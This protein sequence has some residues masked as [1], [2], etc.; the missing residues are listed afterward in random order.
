MWF[1]MRSVGMDFLEDAPR[2]HVVECN[3]ALPREEVWHAIADP[4]TWPHW[5]PSVRSASYL[6]EPPYGVGTTRVSDVRGIRF[7][8]TMLAWDEGRR[9][10]YRIDRATFP[11]AKAQL[12]SSELEDRG[13]GT[14]LRWTLATHPGLVLRLTAPFFQGTLQR[15][16]ERAVAGL[17]DFS[18]RR[19]VGHAGAGTRSATDDAP[20]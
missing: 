14:R 19:E 15:L 10:A 18:H 9:W 7:E 3:V 13:S 5:F 17:E 6:G 4:T 8:E 11:L 16:L 1:E 12:E 20:Q 2:I